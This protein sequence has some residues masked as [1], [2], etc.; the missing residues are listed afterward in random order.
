MSD[1]FFLTTRSCGDKRRCGGVLGGAFDGGKVAALESTSSFRW[2][3]RCCA[4]LYLQEVSHSKFLV[5]S[6]MLIFLDEFHCQVS[7]MS[8]HQ[9]R[10]LMIKSV[11]FLTDSGSSVNPLSRTASY[12]PS[13]CTFTCLVLPACPWC[14]AMT[15]A[16]VASLHTCSSRTCLLQ[17]NSAQQQFGWNRICTSVHAI[18]SLHFS[19]VSLG[20]SL[21]RTF[22]YLAN[23]VPRF[24]SAASFFDICP[25]KMT[26]SGSHFPKS[27]GTNVYWSA[28][29]HRLLHSSFSTSASC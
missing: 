10:N 13:Y 15:I 4:T 7:Q 20:T 24:Q 22:R 29:R 23:H 2:R 28:H 25:R 9:K 11:G 19:N 14:H 18:S 6:V 12:I 16:A 21:G 3:R 17:P 8:D 5:P 26:I 1:D 27:H